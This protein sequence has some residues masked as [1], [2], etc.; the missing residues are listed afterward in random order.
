V[1]P[2]G[3][4]CGPQQGGEYILAATGTINNL[5]F[6]NAGV[7]LFSGSGTTAV[8][9]VN[10][11]GLK[12]GTPG[13]LVTILNYTLNGVVWL[14]HLSPSASQGNKL[15]NTIV[16]M[17]TPLGSNGT[18]TYVYSSDGY[19]HLIAHQQGYPIQYGPEW[20]SLDAP[21]PDIGDGDMHGVFILRGV[22]LLTAINMTMGSTTQFGNN[23][24]WWTVQAPFSGI[25]DT[26]GNGMAIADRL[27]EEQ[28]LT[29][30][31]SAGPTWA[32]LVAGT[33]AG[34][35]VSAAVPWTWA[36]TDQLRLTLDLNIR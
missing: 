16:T 2:G 23:F 7:I 22:M 9:I 4:C 24:W 36:A 17:A 6:G 30:T 27:G 5:D 33:P 1:S 3:C 12:A 10:V 20:H 11:M 18:A 15:F 32:G 29:V 25:I 34:V 8:D 21:G 35:G 19:W 31:Y 26:V 28:D 13:Q 14:Q